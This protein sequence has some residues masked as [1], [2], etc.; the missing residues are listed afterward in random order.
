[1]GT[2]YY[3]II[4][5]ILGLVYVVRIEVFRSTVW[6]CEWGGGGGGGAVIYPVLFEYPR[7][8]DPKP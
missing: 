7:T 2:T 1:M 3:I 5:Y 4:G 8:Y 6:V